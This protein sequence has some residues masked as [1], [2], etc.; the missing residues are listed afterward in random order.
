M[1]RLTSVGISFRTTEHIELANILK[2]IQGKFVLSYNDCEVV[3]DLY[4]GFELIEVET[5]YSL[6]GANK[7]Q[8]KEL[9]IKGV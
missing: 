5:V 1:T 6:N 8:A 2:T 7:K 3:R 9:I 4:K